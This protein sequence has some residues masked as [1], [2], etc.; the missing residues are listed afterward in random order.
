MR[1]LQFGALNIHRLDLGKSLL[2]DADAPSCARVDI[3]IEG[4]DQMARRQVED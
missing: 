3:R 4:Q 2:H 1:P